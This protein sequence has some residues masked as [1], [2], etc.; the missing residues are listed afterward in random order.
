MIKSRSL[1]PDDEVNINSGVDSEVGDFSDDGSGAHDVDD[2]LVDFHFIL[3]PGVGTIT[4]RRSTASDG[5]LLG[6]DSAGTVGLVTLVLG[7]GNNFGAGGLKGLDLSTAEGH[8]D[9]LNF[10][11]DFFS[12]LFVIF[13]CHFR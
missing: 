2:T 11:L 5:E 7:S 1:G 9:A 4:T 6:G 12:F 13:L 10:F 3:I 8:S